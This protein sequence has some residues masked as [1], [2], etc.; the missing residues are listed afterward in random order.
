[1][2]PKFKLS[3]NLYSFPSNLVLYEHVH[4]ELSYSLHLTVPSMILLN[5]TEPATF[6]IL[7]CR[8]FIRDSYFLYVIATSALF[9]PFG[10]CKMSPRTFNQRSYISDP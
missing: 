7:S 9:V 3:Q 4:A 6:L 2:N 8:A 10:G 1:M 5:Q